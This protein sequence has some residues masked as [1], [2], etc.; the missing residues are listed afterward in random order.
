MDE[1]PVQLVKETRRPIE[2]TAKHPRRVDYEYERAGTAEIF[3]FTEPLSGWRMATARQ[4]KTKV[5]WALEMARLLDGR[6]KGM[7][8][9]HPGVRQPKHAYQGGVLR[10]VPSS[11]STPVRPPY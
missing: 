3:M 10:S 2:A 1:Q 7:R 4:S 11:P 5:D 8:Q 6:Y 9:G